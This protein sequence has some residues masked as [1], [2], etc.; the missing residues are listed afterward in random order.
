M[1]KLGAGLASK[2]ANRGPCQQHRS[3][4]PPCAHNYCTARL[5]L[6]LKHKLDLVLFHFATILRLRII[7]NIATAVDSSRPRALQLYSVMSRRVQFEQGLSK[8]TQGNRSQSAPRRSNSACEKNDAF[9][10]VP[11]RRL[12]SFRIGM[13]YYKV[14]VKSRSTKK[15]PQRNSVNEFLS[16]RSFHASLP[17]KTPRVQT[18]QEPVSS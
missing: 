15:D 1:Y 6:R 9:Y 3:W 16:G 7:T 2:Q 8:L 17:E 10:P 14:Q 11:L 13:E 12:S 4:V 5:P 18:K